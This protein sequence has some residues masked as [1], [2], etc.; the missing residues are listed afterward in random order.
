MDTKVG[1]LIYLVPTARYDA[2]ATI[3]ILARCLSFPTIQMEK[4]ADRC[5]RY[6]YSTSN[7]GIVFNGAKGTALTAYSD[8]DWAVPHSTTGYCIIFA[9]A[10][11]GYTRASGSTASP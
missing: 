4:E 11:I 8:S 7:I 10:P 9:G 5:L 2:A 3:G 1:S 6:I